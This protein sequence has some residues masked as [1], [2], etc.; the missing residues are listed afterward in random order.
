MALRRKQMGVA[1][2]TQQEWMRQRDGMKVALRELVE[3]QRI[4]AMVRDLTPEELAIKTKLESDLEALNVRI[5]IALRY[6]P[7][8]VRK[9]E[10]IREFDEISPR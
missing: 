3:R 10:W 5:A 4:V 8:H 1:T 7:G 9:G 6:S 2:P